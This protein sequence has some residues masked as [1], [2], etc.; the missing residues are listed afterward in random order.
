[1]IIL[2]SA[3]ASV[4]VTEVMLSQKACVN[5]HIHAKISVSATSPLF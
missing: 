2:H 5:F 3:Y 1:M 4:I